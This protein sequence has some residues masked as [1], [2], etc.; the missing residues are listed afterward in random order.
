MTL[1][2]GWRD[3]RVAA[4]AGGQ[5][6]IVAHEQLIDLGFGRRT[7]THWV[8]RGRLRVVFHGVYSVVSGALPHLALEQAALLACGKRAFL[9][10]QSAAFVWGL[11]KVQPHQVEVSVVG[12]RCDS[13]KG[14]RA[15][16]I[17]SI[18]RRERRC[19]EGLWV[20]TPARA[21]LEI[22]AAGSEYELCAA[23]DEGLARA[24]DPARAG[25]CPGAKSALPRR[26]PSGADPGR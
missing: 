1:G 24:S 4:L 2:E 20:S 3:A 11:R 23:I 22:A 16:Q 9:S 8:T 12:R 19:H 21:V 7:I 15:H 18:D 14:I 13:R 25:G 26:R 6:T 5:R 10:H 17:Q